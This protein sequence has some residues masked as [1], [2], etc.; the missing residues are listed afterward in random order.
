MTAR[1]LFIAP[2]PISQDAVKRDDIVYL[3]AALKSTN[4]FQIK[5]SPSKISALA[6]RAKATATQLTPALRRASLPLLHPIVIFFVAK[7]YQHISRLLGKD[8]P[9]FGGERL[10]PLPATRLENRHNG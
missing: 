3:A 4:K 1:N 6:R 9:V 10:A 7:L 5:S 8:S 2:L